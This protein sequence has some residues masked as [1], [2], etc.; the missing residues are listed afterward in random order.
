M[1]RILYQSVQQPVPVVAPAPPPP[2]SAWAQPTYLQIPPAKKR[3]MS[4]AIQ[5]S[6]AFVKADPFPGFLYADRWFRELSLP[7]RFKKGLSARHQQTAFHVNFLSYVKGSWGIAGS[8]VASPSLT[9]SDPVFVDRW[10]REFSLPVRKSPSLRTG[11][12]QAVA[13]VQASPFKETVS[14]DRW[15]TPFA[16]PRRYKKRLPTE[17]QQATAFVCPSLTI[18]I[19]TL[20]KWRRDFSEP[21]R[22]E[23][24]IRTASQQALSFSKAEPFAE[25]VSLDRWSAPLSEPVRTEPRLHPGAQQAAIFSYKPPSTEVVYA[26]KW[27]RELSIPVR[28]EP[29]LETAAQ[30]AAAFSKAAPFAE[31]V[32]LDRWRLPLAQ[33]RTRPSL[34]AALNPFHTWNPFAAET[35]PPETISPDKWFAPLSE[36]VRLDRLLTAQQQALALV[37]GAP[38]PE[39][40]SLD[41]WMVPLSGPVLF[42]PDLLTGSNPFSA[43]SAYV[44]APVEAIFSDKWFKA[45]SEPVRVRSS[46]TSKA[47]SGGSFNPAS[48][49]NVV[50]MAAWFASLSE[51]VR[52][53]PGLEPASHP[54]FALAQAAPFGEEINLDKW[55]RSLSE[56]AAYLKRVPFFDWNVFLTVV[57][58][59]TITE[60]GNYYIA[61]A[62]RRSFGVS[63]P[64]KNA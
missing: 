39:S 6:G 5:T 27:F 17:A 53:K 44:Q 57:R 50:I 26:E 4:Q 19:V 55:F 43:W 62:P 12:Q 10:H 56:P 31:S 3:G 20:D 36:F 30:Q 11:A 40:V 34:G 49:P 37:K 9:E 23:P 15:A 7:V 32:T 59:Q 8:P 64:R 52:F 16:E 18:E 1:A 38:F 46:A 45:L 61:T 21:V 48:L 35:I 13:F 58:Q 25:T 24:S 41:R 60:I 2:P 28:Y 51:P 54:A 14:F 47:V 22:F 33:P 42:K 63:S 29:G